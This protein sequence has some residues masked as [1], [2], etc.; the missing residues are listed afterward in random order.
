MQT[1][2]V[3]TFLANLSR[4]RQAA[5]S[6]GILHLVEGGLYICSE[7]FIFF[8]IPAADPFVEDDHET[9]LFQASVFYRLGNVL[10]IEI[11]FCLLR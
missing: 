8:V 7:Q 2:G 10:L 3:R 5:K 9:A 6:L 1:K 11:C 4:V